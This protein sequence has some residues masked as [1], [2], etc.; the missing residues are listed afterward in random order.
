[1]KPAPFDYARPPRLE[2]AVDQLAAATDGRLIAGGQTLGPMLNLRL[3]RPSL[4]VDLGGI[5]SLRRIARTKSTLTLGACVTHA[6][7]ED[8]TDPTPLSRLL[9]FVASGIAF[10]A[11]RN[12]GT[13]GGSLSHADPAADWPSAMLLVDARVQVVGASGKRAIG[14]S[15]FMLGA[16]ATALA[17]DEVLESIEIPQLPAG[18]RWGWW[19]VTR[20]VGEFPDALAGVLSGPSTSCR[21]VM[22][23]VDGPP[24]LLKDL[25]QLISRDGPRAANDAT[26]RGEVRRASSKLDDIEICVHSAAVRRAIFKAFTP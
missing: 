18:S 10:R 11:I 26:I 5:A 20:K 12:R 24:V 25:S 16:Y 3:A 6:S 7:M 19:K 1:V 15:E 21:I 23:A 9:A 17:R 14:M 4:L 13:V 8:D 2:D 22:G